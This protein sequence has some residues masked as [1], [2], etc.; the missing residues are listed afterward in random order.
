MKGAE[1]LKNSKTFIASGLHITINTLLLIVCLFIILFMKNGLVDHFLNIDYSSVGGLSFSI[2]AGYILLSG[3]ALYA[4]P[5]FIISAGLLAANLLRRPSLRLDYKR[6]TITISAPKIYCGNQNILNRFFGMYWFTFTLSSVSA[7]EISYNHEIANDYNSINHILFDRPTYKDLLIFNLQEQFI[8]IDILP[9]SGRQIKTITSLIAE[10]LSKE[11]SVINQKAADSRLG[12][13][14]IF[15]YAAVPFP[16]VI[17]AYLI[18]SVKIILT[19]MSYNIFESLFSE[20]Y[21]TF[22]LLMFIA[23]I[24]LEYC[25]IS[26]IKINAE[27]LKERFGRYTPAA[28]LFHCL[29][30]SDSR[31]A[32][33][34]SIMF[35]CVIFVIIAFI[36]TF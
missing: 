22:I 1:I 32:A 26:I 13:H 28:L 21:H 5:L 12:I 35:L 19:R 14:N 4:F 8:A 29:D 30:A 7:Y 18:T 31:T 16:P 20:E 27:V 24:I 3:N 36:L 11:P 15:L 10:A 17:F 33:Y 23:G 25:I 6:G 9:F 2:A 34:Y